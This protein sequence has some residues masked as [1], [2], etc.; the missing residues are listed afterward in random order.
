MSSGDWVLAD[1]L[2]DR[3]VEFAVRVLKLVEALPRT[4]GARHCGDQLLRAATSPGANYQE[5]RSAESRA[6]FTHK[7][8]IAL[9]EL[10][11]S[12]YWLCVVARA[13][14]LPPHALGLI[15]KEC[16]ELIRIFVSSLK[17]ARERSDGREPHRSAGHI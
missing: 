11:E 6:D 14:F 15:G 16:D 9:K 4:K 17:T 2:G 10:R 1:A 12:Q 7:Y 13:G 8:G 3:L 5:A